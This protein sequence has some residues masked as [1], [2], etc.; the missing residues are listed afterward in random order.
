[1]SQTRNV[2]LVAGP[3]RAVATKGTVWRACEHRPGQGFV[4]THEW[5]ASS[6][7]AL[8]IR[9]ESVGGC[10]GRSTARRLEACPQHPS[11]AACRGGLQCV[12]RA[13]RPRRSE[14]KV[15]ELLVAETP[16]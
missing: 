12:C 16:P 8:G 1:M 15:D 11:G 9:H 5:L 13:Q 7:Q 2:T 10:H 4:L 3:P 14:L 6:Q